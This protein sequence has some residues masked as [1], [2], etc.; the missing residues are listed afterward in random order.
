MLLN[1]LTQILYKMK[2]EISQSLRISRALSVT[3]IVIGLIL[4][5]FMITV[6]DEPGALPLFLILVGTVWFFVNRGRIKR[7]VGKE[8]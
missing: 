3:I 2:N 6:E 5:I 7:Q 8:Y 4:L 1:F